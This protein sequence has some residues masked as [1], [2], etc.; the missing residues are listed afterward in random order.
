MASA[1]SSPLKPFDEVK[2]AVTEFALGFDHNYYQ[3]LHLAILKGDWKSTKAFLDNDPTALTA[4]VTVHGRTA[5]HVAAV[6]AQWK[7]VEKLAQHQQMPAEVLEELDFM[8]CTCLHYVA[9]GQSVDAAK[10]LV[11]KNPSVTQVID[12]KGFTPL[13]Y[14]I[15]STQCKE[16]VG[17]L[18]LNTSD[19]RPGCPF[20][21]PSASQLVALLTGAGF[22]DITMHLLQRYPNLATITDSNGS[23]IILN[24]LTKLPSH[25]YSGDLLY[26]KFDKLCYKWAPGELEYEN[27]IWN[28]LQTLFPGLKIIRDKKLRHLSAVKLAEFVFSQASTMNDYQFWQSFVSPEILFSATSSGIVEILET[29]FQFFPDMVWTRIPNEGYLVQIAIKNRQKQV[30]SFLCKMPIMCKL[31][32]LAI[33]ESNNTTSHLAARFSSQ[34]D[35]NLGAPFQIVRELHWFK[36]VEKLDH[37]LH[38]EVRNIDGKTAWQ[39]FKEEHKTLIREARNWIKD[40]SNT[41]ML[42]ATLIVTITFAA[43]ITVPGGSNQDKGIPIFLTDNKFR[44]FIVSD[45]IAFFFSMASLLW[46]LAAIN[47][48]YIHEDYAMVLFVARFLVGLD[49]LSCAVVATM[50]AFITTLTIFLEDRFKYFI[51]CT[52]LLAYFPIIVCL[53]LRFPF[54]KSIRPFKG[55][56]IF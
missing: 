40:R 41:G 44:V 26:F 47:G 19:E 8:G 45:A 29:C 34:V 20:S 21:G 31:L 52:S 12:F 54:T 37:P 6:G 38:K 39:V 48:R 55:I 9:M 35:S 1:E 36:V 23:S 46:F 15:T 14:S 49:F 13:M 51:I 17:Y 25:F 22:H 11:A 43:A 50:V 28:A 5:L 7:L 32:V 42:V 18:V 30:F 10:A 16:M 33:D 3:P 4:K 56:K 27:T 53:K 2:T 24:V